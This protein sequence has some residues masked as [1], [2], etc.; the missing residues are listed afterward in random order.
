MNGPT[1]ITNVSIVFNRPLVTYDT[2]IEI[3]NISIVLNSSQIDN[4]AIIGDRCGWGD[5]SSW[6]KYF[7]HSAILN[8]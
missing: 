5:Y 4:G 6:A 7:N 2:F 1:V 8:C 3:V